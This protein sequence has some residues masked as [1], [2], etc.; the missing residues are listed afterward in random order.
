MILVSAALLVVTSFERWQIDQPGYV[1]GD[2]SLT[3]KYVLHEIAHRVA[4][5]LTIHASINRIDLIIFASVWTLVFAAIFLVLVI[6]HFNALP[7]EKPTPITH[8]STGQKV[9]LIWLAVT[10][11]LWL[12]AS[13]LF[14]KE[15]A[16]VGYGIKS[17]QRTIMHVGVVVILISSLQATHV[18]LSCVHHQAIEILS[19]EEALKSVVAV[20]ITFRKMRK[21][22]RQ[23]PDHIAQQAQAQ[24]TTA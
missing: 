2:T 13:V 20:F 10:A 18:V 19:W 14:R 4:L 21:A 5:P 17:N 3:S 8:I 12:L 6:V 11:A 7:A 1:Y 9:H 15:M 16:H 22:T 23:E 24:Y